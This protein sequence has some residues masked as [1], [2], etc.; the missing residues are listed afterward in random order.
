MFPRKI[1]D[2]M[3]ARIHQVGEDRRKAK[4]L[5]RE[6]RHLLASLPTSKQLAYEAG[7]CVRR[8]QELLADARNPDESVVSRRT[9]D[10]VAEAIMREYDL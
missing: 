9:P 2:A 4:G 3:R 1:S 5:M 6:G 8:V 7:V 10:E